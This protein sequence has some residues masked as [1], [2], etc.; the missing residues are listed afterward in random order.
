MKSQ[1]VNIHLRHK[2]LL[3]LQL[4]HH[5]GNNSQLDNLQ[6]VLCLQFHY[7][8]FL[9]SMPFN[10]LMLTPLKH[11]YKFLQYMQLEYLFQLHNSFQYFKDHI[12]DQLQQLL[13]N[14]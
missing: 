12:F 13:M 5:Q 2:Q 4:Y 8:I 10:Q 3:V 1:S 6:L 11:H 14:L 9:V 7:N